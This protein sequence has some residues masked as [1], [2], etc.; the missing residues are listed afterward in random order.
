M[1]SVTHT[2]A[3][4]VEGDARSPESAHDLAHLRWL[5][6][7]W[8][9]V[10]AF[11]LTTAAWSHHVGIPLRD[12]DGRMFSHR[13]ASAVVLFGLLVAADALV[14]SL[15]A[16]GSVR[17]AFTTLRLRWPW[18]RLVVA[19]TGLLAY[20]LVYLCY[21]NLKSW[22]AFNTE[23]DDLLLRVDRWL[24]LGHSPAHLLH[25]VLGTHAAAYVLMVV[26]RSFT[27]LIPL[28]V[29]GSLVFVDRIRQGYVLL[30]AAMWLW[31]LGT[32]SY[33]LIPT[34]GPFASDP[35]D[36]VSLPHTAITDS[37]V[38]YLA[39]RAHLLQHPGAHDAFASISAFAS[40]HVGF[41]CLILLML[42]YYGRTLL[43]RLMGVYL[44]GVMLATVYF[45]WHFAVDVVAGVLL[46]V[47]AVQ[48]SRWMIRPG[49][50]T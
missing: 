22:D 12:P 16:T 13:L 6:G 30:L 29:V 3:R 48:L 33:Y 36:F 41:S 45:G 23:R 10:L 21:R 8:A 9:V 26:Y 43:A 47:L 7:V 18:R 4:G 19:L 38:G 11:A 17:G 14:R 44:A 15:R 40:L 27:Y 25:A 49:V 50:R 34:L 46:A 42:R 37:Q 1:L 2:L 32:A 28:A 31:V 20:H 35:G 39:E 24:F 5:S